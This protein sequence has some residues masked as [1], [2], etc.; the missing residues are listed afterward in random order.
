MLPYSWRGCVN[1]VNAAIHRPFAIGIAQKHTIQLTYR[2][3]IDM[4]RCQKEKVY[5][6]ELT[7]KYEMRKGVHLCGCV[8]TAHTRIRVNIVCTVH[9][10]FNDETHSK[11]ITEN[12]WM[13]KICNEAFTTSAVVKSQ[14]LEH[15][16]YR[17]FYVFPLT[18]AHDHSFTITL[19]LFIENKN[20]DNI[21]I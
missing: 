19:A 18:R 2:C 13:K 14:P 5:T 6:H 3:E 21:Y 8:L 9:C 15:A 4:E 10:T 16:T 20:T 11:G 1:T 7:I 12:H 17:G